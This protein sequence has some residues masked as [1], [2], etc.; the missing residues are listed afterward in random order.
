MCLLICLDGTEKRERSSINAIKFF[1]RSTA[2]SLVLIGA[3][4]VL[5]IFSVV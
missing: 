1:N 4:V 2:Q 3:V 5:C